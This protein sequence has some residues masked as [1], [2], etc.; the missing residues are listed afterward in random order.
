MNEIKKN[1]LIKVR[2]LCNI[3]GHIDDLNSINDGGELE[4]SYRNFCLEELQKGKENTNLYEA[5]FVDLDIK[6]RDEKLQVGLLAKRDSS[7]LAILCEFLI[8]Q[9]IHYL[10]QFIYYPIGA[11]PSTIANRLPNSTNY[12]IPN[13]N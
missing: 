4:I 5:K 3:F 13:N 2:K 1:D 7:P 11:E 6:I 9:V 12:Q 8:G 10:T